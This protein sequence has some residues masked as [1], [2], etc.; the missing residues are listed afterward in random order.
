MGLTRQQLSQLYR[1][2]GNPLLASFSWASGGKVNTNSG[3]ID[4]SLPI[5][6]L[7]ITVSGRLVIG[8]AA[9]G[10]LYPSG[11]LGLIRRIYVYGV[12]SAM[13]GQVTLYDAS[14]SDLWDF[15]HLT[16]LRSGH[17]DINASSVAVPSMPYPT[18]YNPTGAT[19]TFDFRLQFDLPFHPFNCPE[20]VRPGYLVR[21]KEWKNTL[22]LVMEFGTQAGAGATGFLGVS[23]GTSTVAFSSYGSGGGSP[24][25]NVYGLPVRMGK[26]VAPMVDTP[27]LLSRVGQPINSIL[28]AAG[29][30]VTLL[31]LQNRSTT[32]IFVRNGTLTAGQDN[33]AT[34][35]DV[36]LTSLGL[37]I[38]ASKVIRPKTDIIALKAE[39]ALAYGRDPIQGSVMMDF[40]DSANPDS[41]LPAD[42]A[43]A[44]AQL[45]LIGDVAS[46]ASGYGTVIQEQQLLV[47]KGT[48]YAA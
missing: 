11:L 14:L 32:R 33:F 47:P 8:T 18:T 13:G 27:G 25:I 36:N 15:A 12:N 46:L 43:D 2:G 35:S 7:R 1:P 31:T 17:L 42:S 5:R 40:M 37:N 6:G 28:Q 9:F 4:L 41:A 10:T 30:G 22:A 23:G 34:L 48:L 21:G 19:G 3:Q 16:Q 29:T 38:G 45:N 24:L 20:L 39:T 26:D 44:N